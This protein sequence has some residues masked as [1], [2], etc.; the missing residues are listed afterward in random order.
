MQHNIHSDRVR[1]R[2]ILGGMDM[3]NASWEGLEGLDVLG[4]GVHAIVIEGRF[5]GV[6]LSS[7]GVELSSLKITYRYNSLSSPFIHPSTSP[8]NHP[9]SH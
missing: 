3:V 5:S 8:S 2:Y 7:G 6:E 9:F 4:G 1:L